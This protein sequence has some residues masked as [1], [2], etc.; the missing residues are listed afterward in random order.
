L[1]LDGVFSY[2]HSR[3]PTHDDLL[4]ADPVV[5]TPDGTYWNPHS[6]HY[7]FNEDT[8]NDYQ[9]NMMTSSYIKTN[10]IEDTDIPA[11]D[12]ADINAVLKAH[13]EASA[14]SDYSDEVAATISAIASTSTIF[15]PDCTSFEDKINNAA[16]ISDFKCQLVVLLLSLPLLT[17]CSALNRSPSK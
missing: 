10:L 13:Y 15:T 2:F 12:C 1:N 11:I 4:N 5:V 3:K 6:E 17:H 16:A 14:K 7:S 9:G 8:F